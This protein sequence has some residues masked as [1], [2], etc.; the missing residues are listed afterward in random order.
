[1]TKRIQG[2]VCVP[3]RAHAVKFGRLY[4]GMVF[5]SSLEPYQIK[6]VEN[7]ASLTVT[8]ATLY[9]LLNIEV[10]SEGAGV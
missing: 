7:V 5:W 4:T 1:M 2:T 9:F 8:L 3:V 10:F 6:Q